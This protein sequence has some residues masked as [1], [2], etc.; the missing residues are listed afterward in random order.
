MPTADVGSGM[1]MTDAAL[2]HD[3]Q[4][5]AASALFRHR[6]TFNVDDELF[7]ALQLASQVEK[8]TLGVVVRRW[9]RASARQ[10]GAYPQEHTNVGSPGTELE[11]AL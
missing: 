11:F 5:K 9:L 2:H 4:T 10:V 7:G 8:E 6:L 1:Q 3:V